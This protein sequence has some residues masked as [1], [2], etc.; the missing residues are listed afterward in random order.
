MFR[1][2]PPY[3]FAEPGFFDFRNDARAYAG[4]EPRFHLMFCSHCGE[5]KEIGKK[6][7]DQLDFLDTHERC[8]PLQWTK[9]KSWWKK[10]MTRKMN[11]FAPGKLMDMFSATSLWTVD[12]NGHLKYHETINDKHSAIVLRDD[13][14]TMMQILFRGR[15]Y[16]VHRICVKGAAPWIKV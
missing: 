16:M 14:E 12:G 6:D 9:K 1:F 11:R 13:F 10:L 5:A 7:W 15:V 2:G 8:S 4:R 3:V